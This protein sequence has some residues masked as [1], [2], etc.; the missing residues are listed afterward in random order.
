MI[1]LAIVEN[2]RQSRHR[3]AL[4]PQMDAWRREQAGVPLDELVQQSDQSWW[5]TP[6]R[7]TDLD[8]QGQELHIVVEDDDVIEIGL[9]ADADPEAITAFARA[10]GWVAED[11]DADSDA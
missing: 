7:I 5:I 11:R 2:I 6:D 10:Q 4:A 1:L 9:P 3:R 8:A